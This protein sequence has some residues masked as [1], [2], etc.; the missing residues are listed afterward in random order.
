MALISTENTWLF[1]FGI[2]GNI[3]SFVVFMAPIPTFYRIWKKKSTEGFQSLPYLA[4]LFSAMLWIYYASLK[5]D[6]FLLITINSF[7]CLV[8]TIY[9]AFYIMYAPK[10][11]RRLVIR[12]KSVEFMPFHLSL[13]LTVSAITWLFYG[14]FLKDLYVAI[15]NILGFI[16]G[17]LQLV[18]YAVYRN[19]SKMV[20]VEGAQLPQHSIDMTKLSTITL[21]S[22]AKPNSTDCKGQNMDQSG[23]IKEFFD[24]NPIIACEV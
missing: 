8:E 17:F 1:I 7:G 4:G 21:A 13:F 3:S 23:K 20:V 19:K 2:L 16:F 5:S 18:L 9:I 10:K 14:I 6:A 11:A 15:P 12:T 24:S 22:E